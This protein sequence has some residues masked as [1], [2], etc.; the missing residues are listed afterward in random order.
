[1]TSLT[2]PATPLPPV[3]IPANAHVPPVLYKGYR[4][5]PKLDFGREHFLIN[6][7]GVRQ[8]YVVTDGTCN[9][10][11]GGTW[12][13]TV[14]SAQHAINVFIRV[15]G[16]AARFWE[17]IQ[18]FKYTRLG[19]R[20][21]FESGS[22]SCGRCAATIENFKVVKLTYVNRSGKLITLPKA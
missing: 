8:G 17:I 7:R 5:V 19:Q 6:G 21:D 14:I 2:L 15:K 4:I 12:F 10:M 22:V 16:H 1:M 9:I 13:E 11:P 3:P 20:A 18:P